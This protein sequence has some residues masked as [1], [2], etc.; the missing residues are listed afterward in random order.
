MGVGVGVGMVV[1][2]AEGWKRVGVGAPPNGIEQARLASSSSST[3]RRAIRR[4]RTTWTERVRSC[5]RVSLGYRTKRSTCRFRLDLKLYPIPGMHTCEHPSEVL[6][7][8]GQV[9]EMNR[10]QHLRLRILFMGIILATLPCYCLGWAIVRVADIQASVPTA[11]ATQ[12]ATWT[13]TPTYTL[14]PSQTLPPSFTPAPPTETPTITLTPTIFYTWT[15]SPTP[16]PTRT[17]P[18][19]TPTPTPSHTPPP[20]PPPPTEPLPPTPTFTETAT[21]IPAETPTE[22]ATEVIAETPLATDPPVPSNPLNSP[23]RTGI[24]YP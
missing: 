10:E 6:S 21:E 15:P 13:A 7:S 3:D 1:G 9:E 14:A 19:P 2:V 5:I 8:G 24:P 20:P 11:T 12:T 22:T 16:S 23:D 4:A 17:S 18:P